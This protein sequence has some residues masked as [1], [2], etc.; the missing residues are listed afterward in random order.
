MLLRCRLHLVT[1][2]ILCRYFVQLTKIL[3]A[4]LKDFFF[5]K[6]NLPLKNTAIHLTTG[7]EIQPI[8]R[9]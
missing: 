5:V 3:L 6:F 7:N 2:F 1:H 9:K 8:R 4:K